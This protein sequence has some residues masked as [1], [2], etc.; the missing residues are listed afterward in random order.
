M[1]EGHAKDATP[2][3][4]FLWADFFR[5][6]INAKLIERFLGNARKKAIAP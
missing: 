3:S 4:E 2:F 6:P 5:T 1:R